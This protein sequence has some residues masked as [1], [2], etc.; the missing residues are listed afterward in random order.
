MIKKYITGQKGS[1]RFARLSDFKNLKEYSDYLNLIYVG[2]TL[3]DEITGY[4]QDML[5]EQVKNVMIVG[6][7]GSAKTTGIIET[8]ILYRKK[9]FLMV[10]PKGSSYRR[11]ASILKA[12]GYV[13]YALAPFSR[14]LSSSYNPLG[15][16]DPDDPDFPDYIDL[17]MSALIIV[18]TSDPHWG[19]AARR[20]GA[21]LIAYV[22]E[23]PGEEASLGRVMEILSGG[24]AVISHFARKVVEDKTTYKPNSLARRKLARFAEL[25]S[26]NREAQSILSNALSELNI[27][28]SPAICD[29]LSKGDFNPEILLDPDRKVAV[30]LILAPEKLET[31]N[32]FTR[33][34]ISMVINTISR[35]GGDPD[36]PIDL[37]ID[38][39][40]TI[41][42]LPI[43]SQGIALMREKGI[44]FWTVFQSLSQIQRDYPFDWKNFISNCNPIFFLD[45]FDPDDL[46]YFSLLLGDATIEQINGREYPQD[47]GDLPY[48][49]EHTFNN[50]HNN[51]RGGGQIS[52]TFSRPLMTPD[53]LRRL[54]EDLGIVITDGHPAIFVKAKSYEAEPF[55]HVVWNDRKK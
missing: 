1:A 12:F 37:Y 20:L 4:Q 34:I 47:V 31:Y 14:D 28:D 50:Y 38:E 53:E 49:L 55:C 41:G 10:D 39:A 25:N 46:E 27:L 6:G 11:L 24:L 33:L 2:K 52:G 17:L 26:E 19:N 18:S 22:I 21:G 30:F 32:K 8:N 48:M 43:L 7:T 5:A 13:V 36:N 15:V 42:H 44:C 35:I 40:G 45:A 54:P 51:H 16:P 23:T 29:F 9:S 3:P